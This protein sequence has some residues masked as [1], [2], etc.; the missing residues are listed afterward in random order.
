MKK[1]LIFLILVTT[2]LSAKAENLELMRRWVVFPFGADSS[3]KASAENAWWKFREKLTG[4]R[5]YLVASRQF[6][7]QK[8]A[9]QPRKELSPDDV[10]LLGHLLDA[11]VI[12]TGY[13]EHRQFTVNVYLTQNGEL[14]WTKHISFHPSLKESDQ[15]EL[16]SEKLSQDLLNQIP[17]HAFTVT[18]PLIGKAVYE[19]TNKKYAVI[20]VGNSDDLPV[21]AAIQWV[22]VILPERKD[23]EPSK[24]PLADQTKIA[25]I[26]EGKIVKIKKGV[27]IAEIQK[28]TTN[29]EIKEKTLVRIPFEEKKTVAAADL[30]TQT[31]HQ[32]LVPEMVP[33]VI[34]PVT[35]DSTGARKDTLIFGSIFGVLG[36]IALAL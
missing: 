27:V 24:K 8:D 17:Y 34:A 4:D 21:G 31:I 36:I 30:D 19:E 7:V 23:G 5:K 14:F 26:G 11:D 35:A 33:T 13:S 9:F 29:D 6:L 12:V 1:L 20:D 32:H 25:V 10:K 16:V 2:P 22:N 28:A 15:L 18:D 3:L